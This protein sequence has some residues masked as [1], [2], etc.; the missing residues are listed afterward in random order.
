M[1][2][3]AADIYEHADDA[4]RRLLNQALFK[5]IYIDEDNDVRVGY[6]NPYDG[7]SS[8]VP[9]TVETAQSRARGYRLLLGRGM[10]QANMTPATSRTRN[11]GTSWL[12]AVVRI[13][14]QMV[15]KEMTSPAPVLAAV[16]W[17]R[18]RRRLS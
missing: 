8:P 2:S 7:L 15:S 13:A 5:M 16:L 9:R 1:L 14:V 11:T 17:I 6:R 4:N 3:N 12:I 18:S 10:R